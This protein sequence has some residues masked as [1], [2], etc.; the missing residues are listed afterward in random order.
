MKKIL[1]SSLFA[2][3]LILVA[4]L[5]QVFAATCP[6]GKECGWVDVS[7]V[8]NFGVPYANVTQNFYNDGPTADHLCEMSGYQTYTYD[9]VLGQ[10]DR[11]NSEYSIIW[12]NGAWEGFKCV[13]SKW[14]K[15]IYCARP[16]NSAPTISW[17]SVP[18]SAQCD[19]LYQIQATADDQDGN[20]MYVNIRK[21][22]VA[23][24]NA[25]GGDGST[26]ISENDSLDKGPDSIT[27]TAWA[28][29]AKGAV[30]GTIS[31]TINIGD[32]ITP[33]TDVCPNI[34]GV[35]TS[36]PTGK[37][38]NGSGD[39][40]DTTTTT[41]DVCANIPGTQASAPTG[42]SISGSNCICN[43]SY[44]FNS[45]YTCVAPPVTNNPPT[46]SFSA[47]CSAFSGSATDSN[48]P[49]QSV[50]VHFY[51]DG[52][53]GSGSWG[54][55]T[56]TD[57]SGNYSYPT[58]VSLK[59]NSNRVIYAYAIDTTAE[60]NAY[61]GQSTINCAPPV[62][63]PGD[64]T[65]SIGVSPTQVSSGGGNVTITWSASGA[66]SCTAS[67]S[68][69]GTKATSGNQTVSVSQASTF[70]L[71]CTGTNMNPWSGS[72]SVTVAAAPTIDV[73]PNIGGDQASVP[74][75]MTVNASGDC[76]T[77]G[78][79]QNGITYNSFPSQVTPGQSFNVSV[80]NNGTKTWGAGHQLGILPV[81]QNA[82][83]F[84]NLATTGIGGQKTVGMTAPTTPGSYVLQA[85]EQGEEWFGGTKAFTVAA[86]PPP[87]FCT[88]NPTDPSCTSG[89]GGNTGTGTGG[90]GCVYPA[91]GS[92]TDNHDGGYLG[93]NWGTA[94]GTSYNQ[95][96]WN[97]TGVASCGSK[98][99]SGFENISGTSYSISCEGKNYSVA[100]TCT[101]VPPP[102]VCSG[103]KVKSG[104]T[105][106]CPGSKP[107]NVSGNICVAPSFSLSATPNN[108]K[109]RS[110]A[111]Y[112]GA[113]DETINLSVNTSYFTAPVSLE[114]SSAPADVE[115]VFSYNGSDFSPNLTIPF[116]LN[117]GGLQFLPVRVR[118]N[119]KLS[120]TGTYSITFRGV[121]VD[122]QVGT[123]T[124]TAT[125]NL[126]SRPLYPGYRE[127]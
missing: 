50:S 18:A 103:D 29:D 124:Q 23:F 113:A 37:E 93:Y 101:V 105:C 123:I 100:K 65:G 31:H 126:D 95:V 96:T 54:G 38:I 94:M 28:T 63:P 53:A 30:S 118:F 99:A 22:G 55:N 20:L 2:G 5:T 90:G 91:S 78:I 48:T 68:W 89:P 3:V 56:S 41:T 120:E 45:S 69:S 25:G 121:G 119:K 7:N 106:V 10:Y 80:T 40:V 59:T 73:C 102:V 70:N 84:A 52:P 114:V 112:A 67:G 17:T 19:A 34:D 47:G 64:I 49:G 76:V 21:D 117:S 81:G 74:T 110:V 77:V 4:G 61:I 6:A 104:S 125:V 122:S 83:F 24:A 71:S 98:P 46:G 66:N 107:V 44:V 13:S 14:F 35:Q 108:V 11:C 109:I 26:G 86:T 82:V 87:S 57:S 32:C 97:V 115:P 16:A 42:T 12:K 27:Y 36:V 58:P 1:L 15:D 85:V 8:Y 9:A 33:P 60:P 39:C 79:P 111:G 116:T 92:V 43:N 51:V 127:F 75:G 72:A 62:S 88:L